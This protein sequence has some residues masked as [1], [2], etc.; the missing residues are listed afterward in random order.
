MATVQS[1]RSAPPSPL[2]PVF[3]GLLIIV[4]SRMIGKYTAYQKA[5]LAEQAQELHQLLAHVQA[6]RVE[7]GPDTT[8]ATVYPG[9]DDVDPLHRA[10]QLD[11]DDPRLD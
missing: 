7:L 10:V 9:R 11:P 3:A 6:L 1:V 8:P 4:G 5:V 2:S